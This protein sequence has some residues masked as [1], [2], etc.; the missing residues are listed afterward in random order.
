MI[1][2][3]IRNAIDFCHE[4]QIGAVECKGF[5]PRPALMQMLIRFTNAKKLAKNAAVNR[6]M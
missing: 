2:K 6:F 5:L 4:T 1:Q 3:S